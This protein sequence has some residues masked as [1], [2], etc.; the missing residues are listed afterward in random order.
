MPVVL[1]HAFPL[2]S[3]MWLAQREGLAGRCRVITPDLRGFGGSVLD[4]EE[5][6]LD[7]MADDVARLLDAEGIDRAVIGGHSMGGY[8]TMAFCR[9]H[10]ERVLGVILAGTKA[11]ADSEAARLARERL[12][13]A[14]VAS[15]SGVLVEEVL[16][17]LVGATTKAR[18]GM[19]FGRVRGL[20]QA[21]PPRAV[22]WA[23]RAMAAR[24]DSFDTLAK[25]A[26]PALVMVGEED[27]LAPVPEARAMAEAAPDSRLEIVE[28]AGHLIAVEQPEAFNRIV[29]GFLATLAPA[30]A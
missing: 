10:P 29:A 13:E 15:G 2:S 4:E 20:V 16:P 8:V 12:A 11:G 30:E 26:V 14:V 25:L 6:S 22:A 5:P 17:G 3:A 27:E 19:V 21:A 24:P 1:L 7:A 18:R 28:K 9:R 23:A